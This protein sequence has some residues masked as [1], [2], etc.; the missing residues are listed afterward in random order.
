MK[1]AKMKQN[2]RSELRLA[3]PLPK[4]I[5]AVLA[6][7]GLTQLALAATS[8]DIE[9][10]V[11]KEW[12]EI[13]LTLPTAPVAENLLAFYDSGSQAFFIDAKSLSVNSDGSVRYTLVSNSSGG[14]KNISYEGIRCQTGEKKLYAF[15]R[16][17]G[18]WS[19]SRRDQ[20]ERIS[21]A[22]ANKQH[23]TL[24][25]DYFCEGKSIAGKAEQIITR[26]KHKQVLKS[27]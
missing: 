19:N 11:N 18:S 16:S 14:A 26:I 5:L 24:F 7:S 23:N 2:R 27:F 4:R 25:Y 8:R 15:G 21:D 12:Q 22:G 17:D 6:L 3:L 13:A 10:E 20:W 1:M 9:E